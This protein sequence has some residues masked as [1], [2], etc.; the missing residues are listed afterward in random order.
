MSDAHGV[1]PHGIPVGASDT[2]TLLVGNK[3]LE[4]WQRVQVTRPLSG[5]PASF[6]LEVTEKYPNKPD[7]DIKPGDPCQVKIGG[8][9]V[10]TGY[11]DRYSAAISPAMHTIR[12]S[13][14]S[15]SE[16]LVDC[17]AVF[18][19]INQPGFQTVNGTTLALV[20]QLAAPYD[21]H[22]QTSAGDGVTIPQ[23]NINLGETPWE[24]ID[25]VTRY[26]QMLV[27]DLPDGSI[28]LAK[29][30]TDAMAS[31]FSIGDNVEHADVAFTMDG[32][33]S[34]YEGHLTSILT[35]GT[36]AGVNTPGVGEVIKDEGVPRFRK[37]YVISEQ[38]V[39]GR[40]IVRDRAIWEMNK[41]WGQSYQFNVVCDSWR[42]SAGKL[43]EPNKLCP[44]S[45]AVLKLRDV[46]YLIGTVS[47]VRDENGQHANLALWPPQAFAI[48]PSGPLGIVTVEDV[49]NSNP[50]KK[51]VD[52]ARV[53]S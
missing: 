10:L 3:V 49:E 33:F 13:G 19:D 8:D 7:A 36:D 38:F 44:I 40:N 39:N 43:W 5:I 23:F 27:Y 34:Q 14:R 53:P 16:D 9:L 41:R 30:G 11:V 18:G 12:V 22:V 4:G 32:R 45:A 6:D 28:M 42:D 52:T 17:S 24:I 50:T 26:S 20:E 51:Q 37:R 47:Y 46:N 1:A 31:G 48:E 2:L 21:I 25:R 29:V 35:F 15:K